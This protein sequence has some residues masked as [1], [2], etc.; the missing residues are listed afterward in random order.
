VSVDEVGWLAF[1]PSIKQHGGAGIHG[2]KGLC[3]KD[4]LPVVSDR[5]NLMEGQV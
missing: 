3:I 1:F 5:G 4:N 2:L